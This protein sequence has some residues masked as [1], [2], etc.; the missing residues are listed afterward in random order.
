MSEPEFDASEFGREVAAALKISG[1]SY[2]EAGRVL[3]ID[4]ATLHRI[5]H[6]GKPDVENYVRLRHW[7]GPPIGSASP[8]SVET[9]EAVANRFQFLVPAASALIRQQA[10]RIAQLEAALRPFALVAE[11]DIGLDEADVDR[12][13]PMTRHNRAPLLRVGDLRAARKALS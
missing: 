3:G 6:G 7:M 12:F 4:Q 8:L 5:A 9:S 1:W 10:A 2:R 11:H 13:R